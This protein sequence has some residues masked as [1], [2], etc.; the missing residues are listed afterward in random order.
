MLSNISNQPLPCLQLTRSDLYRRR[1]A[2]K[3]DNSGNDGK[4][5]KCVVGVENRPTNESRSGKRIQTS[6]PKV[7]KEG[8]KVKHHHQ[9]DKETEEQG[10]F[11]HL[12]HFLS[13]IQQLNDGN[14]SFD[15]DGSYYHFKLKLT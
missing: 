4:D 8:K 15:L 7:K 12:N 2:A 14:L 10:G 9:D 5:R 11:E 6:I 3:R 1:E 13:N